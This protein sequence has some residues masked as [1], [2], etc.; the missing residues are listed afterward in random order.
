[1]MQGG[2]P[3]GTGF[4]GNTDEDGVEINITG[5]FTANG[6]DNNLSHTR[7]AI[8]M[9]RGDDYNSASSQFFIVHTDDYTETLDG[10]YAVF[11]YVIEGIDIVDA[12]C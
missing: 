11:G 7:G 9:A 5:E 10:S 3:E 4:G 12:I 1:M 8:S 6:S 2:D